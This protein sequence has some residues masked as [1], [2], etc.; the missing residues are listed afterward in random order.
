VGEDGGEWNV[1][2]N[3]DLA[4]VPLSTDDVHLNGK[5]VNINNYNAVMQKFQSGSGGTVNIN[6]GASLT[7]SAEYTLRYVG[8]INVNS[9]G[10]LP[11]G[12]GWN[13][14]ANVTIAEGGEAE[15][16]KTIGTNENKSLLVNGTWSPRGIVQSSGLDFSLG[17]SLSGAGSVRLQSAGTIYLDIYGDGTNEYFN[18]TGPRT[19]AGG[20]LQLDVGSIVLRP[21][22]EYAPE[23]GHSYDL[24]NIH[25]EA[26]A[27]LTL[28]DG[29][30][31]SI[32]DLNP[33]YSLDVSRWETDG[34][35][36]VVPEPGYL[37]LSFGALVLIRRRWLG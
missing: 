33:A 32:Q 17:N 27:T 4:H 30:N 19:S 7:G 1:A 3:W 12:P 35:V 36:T 14:R 11:I 22:N 16:G 9:G 8:Q 13:I 10:Y 15:G 28:G 2:E 26:R 20:W 23:M 31:I 5:T 6:D 29:S 37:L 24:W 34:I 18:V 21:Q 25:E